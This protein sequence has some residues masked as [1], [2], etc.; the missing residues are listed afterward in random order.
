MKPNG[1]RPSA[2]LSSG[3]AALETGVRRCRWHPA[4][5]HSA[6]RALAALALAAALNG[7]ATVSG[8]FADDNIEPPA[9]LTEITPAFE[10][11][12][13]WSAGVG[14][15]ADDK[16]LKLGPLVTEERVVVVD[17]NGLVAA[18]ERTGGRRLWQVETELDLSSAPGG[19]Q[20]LIVVGTSDAKIV[21]LSAENGKELWRAAV[22]SEVLS[23]PRVSEGVVV[24][25][26][27]D[28]H[29]YGLDA[30]TGERRWTFQSPV[31][32]LTLRGTSAPAIA[33]DTVV[34]GM[35]NG[36]LVALGLFDG[37]ERWSA[38]VSEPHGRSDLERMVDIDADPEIYGRAVFAAA[39]Q[40]RVAGVDLYGGKPG[41]GAAISSVAGLG[42]DLD[43]VYVTDQ[44]SEVH[45]LTRRGGESVWKQDAL[46]ARNLT[47]PVPMGDGVVV[48]DLEGWLHWLAR[49]DGRLLARA[50]VESDPI[51]AAPVVFDDLLYVVDAQGRVRAMGILAED[52]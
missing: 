35:D 2:R 50:R 42:V 9:P 39:Y 27:L 23:P 30:A 37:T 49:D 45:A 40:G 33:G 14:D 17:A 46:R 15:G 41:W 16:F 19:N 7:C 8:W 5:L 28:G 29:V 32:A 38:I 51:L 22:S 52:Y 13:L 25:R 4:V 31:P 10:V 34:C 3:D 6:A 36:K 1:Y 43:Q 18:F 47:R 44:D 21:A 11:K 48:G 20:E 24:V 26:C 12:T